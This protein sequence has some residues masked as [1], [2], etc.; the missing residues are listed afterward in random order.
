MPL[1][2][3]QRG[4]SILLLQQAAIVHLF[5]LIWGFFVPATPFPRMALTAHITA[6]SDSMSLLLLGLILRF[7]GLVKVEQWWMRAMIWPSPFFLWATVFSECA[8]SVWGANKI[9]PI[10]AAASG[11]HGAKEWQET[12]VTLCHAIGGVNYVVCWGI[13]VYALFAGVA[14]QKEKKEKEA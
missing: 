2:S 9:L 11:A 13:I 1:I 14:A 10:S 3:N 8:N 7:E 4:I 12:V 5:G 6:M